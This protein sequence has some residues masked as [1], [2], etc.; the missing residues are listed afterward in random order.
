MNNLKKELIQ[1]LYFSQVQF[2]PTTNVEKAFKK[3]D[4][5]GTIFTARNISH[6]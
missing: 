6:S 3:R 1:T 5:Y 2:V 4:F